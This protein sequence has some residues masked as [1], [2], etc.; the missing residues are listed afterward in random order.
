MPLPHVI[1]IQ[2]EAPAKPAL[3]ETCNGCGICC[4]S[5]PCPLGVLLSLSN[6]GPCKA[7]QWSQAEQQYRCGALG[8]HVSGGRGV[9]GLRARLV[10][11]W[12]SA[13]S[14][15]DC[16]LEVSASPTMTLSELKNIGHPH[17]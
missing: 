13:G 7:L 6:K 11:R 2:A 5:E 12:I 15:C 9:T 16:E 8:D 10:G 1:R 14:G 4:L 3:G 17:D